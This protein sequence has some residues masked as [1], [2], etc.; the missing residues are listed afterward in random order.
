MCATGML[1]VIAKAN[2][3]L[4]F[5]NACSIPILLF[6]NYRFITI[7]NILTQ[8]VGVPNNALQ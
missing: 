7:Q 3:Y 6:V 1:N 8:F 2:Y 4:Q 5:Q